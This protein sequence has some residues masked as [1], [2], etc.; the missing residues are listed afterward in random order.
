MN[1]NINSSRAGEASTSK[2]PKQGQYRPS[3]AKPA[4]RVNANDMLQLLHGGMKKAIERTEKAAE[5]TE[6]AATRNE[7]TAN[8]VDEAIKKA[9]K[10]SSQNTAQTLGQQWFQFQKS[11]DGFKSS[12]KRWLWWIVIAILWAVIAS[13]LAIW[14]CSSAIDARKGVKVMQRVQRE[15]DS[16]QRQNNLL[17]EFAEDNPQTFKKWREKTGL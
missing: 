3:A 10:E 16:L 7:Q 14:Q 1:E 17:W 5:R 11:L 6:K 13:G 8:K 12:L 2:P 4:E 9:V 15:R